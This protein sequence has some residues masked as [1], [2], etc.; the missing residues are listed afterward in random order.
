VASAAATL[1]KMLSS[2][3]STSSTKWNRW[4]PPLRGDQVDLPSRNLPPPSTPDAVPRR[5]SLL[6]C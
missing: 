1:G 6:S 5:W 2:A 3:P 4:P